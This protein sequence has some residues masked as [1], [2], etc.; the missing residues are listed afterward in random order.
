MGRVDSANSRR[1]GS[2]D[3]LQHRV[4]RRSSK[5]PEVNYTGR[6]RLTI[7]SDKLVDQIDGKDT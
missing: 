2:G 7:E 3:G 4:R 1:D 5:N 6:E